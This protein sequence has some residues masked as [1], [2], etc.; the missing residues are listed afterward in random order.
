MNKKITTPKG[1]IE[2]D[3][4]AYNHL[5]HILGMSD[6]E[7]FEEVKEIEQKK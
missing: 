7:I 3:Y 5:K 1:T 6:K 2:I 4:P